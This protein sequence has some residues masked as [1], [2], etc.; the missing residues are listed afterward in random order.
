MDKF[1]KATR[2]KIMSKIRSRNTSIEV[3]VRKWL[4]AYGYRFRIND[5]R[6]PGT[7]DIVLPKY[8]TMIFINGCFWHGHNCK[9][10]HIPKT[11]V[12]YWKNKIERNKQRDLKIYKQL[13]EM[14]WKVITLWEC[15]IKSDPEIRLIKLLQEIRG[16]YLK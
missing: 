11:N 2:S 14:G 16:E 15:E 13:T 8:K 9:I 3:I 7:P 10:G 4:F 1:D 6:Y 12:K 5:K